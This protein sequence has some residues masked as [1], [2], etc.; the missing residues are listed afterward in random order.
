[1]TRRLTAALAVPLAV[2]TTAAAAVFPSS[3]PL[4]DDFAPE[5]VTVGRG[6]TFYAGSLRDGDIFR[7][8]LRTGEGRV[9]IDVTGRQAA[10]LKVDQRHGLLFVAGGTTGSAFVYDLRDGSTVAE[11]ALAPAGA[12][13]IND[14]VVTRQ[15]AWFT[16]SFG[17]VLYLVPFEP[18]GG[19][20][21]PV[22]L[23]LTGP[24]ATILGIGLNGIEATSDGRTL[25][26]GHTG[27]GALFT[28][29]PETGASQE[30]QLPAGTI[31]PDT[32]D[33]LL[34]DG[35]TLWTVENFANE[36]TAITLSPDLTSGTVSAVL[37]NADVGG[38][39]RVPTTLAEHG[40]RLVL[41]NGR[42]DLGFPPPF[43]PGAPP[44]TDF[45]VV[46]VDKP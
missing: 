20:G 35:R 37:T 24:A 12:S 25:I 10:G 5:G 40:H 11:I 33:G 41:V 39:F 45:D 31:T 6:T 22:A 19:L 9:F 8:D 34:L 46:V 30:I 3:I 15:G 38:L 23:P 36:V 4:P 26:V 42:F 7:G 27:L 16:D 21:D 1:M 14:V 43:G 28:V 44:G 32:L 17:P 29:D 2:L 18:G 13:L